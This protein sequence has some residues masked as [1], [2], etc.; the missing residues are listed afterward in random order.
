MGKERVKAVLYWNFL[1]ST[2]FEQPSLSLHRDSV[3]ISCEMERAR[4]CTIMFV[5]MHSRC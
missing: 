2:R 5:V 1:K 3:L 4:Y